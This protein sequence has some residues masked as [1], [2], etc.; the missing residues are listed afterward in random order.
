MISAIFDNPSTN[1]TKI[2][3]ALSRSKEEAQQPSKNLD[4]SLRV[5]RLGFY[6]ST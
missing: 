4:F 3:R 6:D 1:L 5:G 2:Y